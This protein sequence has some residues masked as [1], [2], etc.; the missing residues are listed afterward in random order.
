MPLSHAIT[1]PITINTNV[2][3]DALVA[4]S[5]ESI[6]ENVAGVMYSLPP[7]PP[8]VNN[9]VAFAVFMHFTY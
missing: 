1:R 4:S 2:T 7:Q 8:Y 6:S 9:I 3:S 5:L